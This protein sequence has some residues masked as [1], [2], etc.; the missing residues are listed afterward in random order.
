[1]EKNKGK[2]QKKEEPRMFVGGLFP[3]TTS[4]TV[5][6]YFQTFGEVKDVKIIGEKQK[7]SRGFGF[8]LFGSFDTLNR[9]MAEKHLIDGREVDCNFAVYSN[10]TDKDEAA[11]KNEKKIFLSSL[12][13]AVVK[14]DLVDTFESFGAIEKVMIV[15]RKNKDHSFGFVIFEDKMSAKKALHIKKH[16]IRGIECECQIAQPKIRSYLNKV[17]GGDQLDNSK[18]LQDTFKVKKNKK[19]KKR[20]KKSKENSKAPSKI[21]SKEADDLYHEQSVNNII[22]D[23]QNNLQRNKHLPLDRINDQLLLNPPPRRHNT[24]DMLD[25]KRADQSPNPNFDPQPVPTHL[26]NSK[27]PSYYPESNQMKGQLN[28]I[29]GTQGMGNI[30]NMP[31]QPIHNLHPGLNATGSNIGQF[32]NYNYINN[33]Y[34]FTIPQVPQE[35]GQPIQTHV[36]MQNVKIAQ[37]QRSEAQSGSSIQYLKNLKNK[38]KQ[39]L[40]KH[41]NQMYESHQSRNVLHSPSQNHDLDQSPVGARSKHSNS[42]QISITKII[43][44]EAKIRCKK[45]KLKIQNKNYRFNQNMNGS[46]LSRDSLPSQH[47]FG[48][49]ESA[50]FP[51]VSASMLH[52]N[53]GQTQ[54][55]NQTNQNDKMW[56]SH[57]TQITEQTNKVNN[58]T[59]V[60]SQE[61]LGE[62]GL[63]MPVTKDKSLVVNKQPIRRTV[64]QSEKEK[65]NYKPGDTPFKDRTS[66]RLGEVHRKL[67][68]HS[69][70]YSDRVSLNREWSDQSD[71]EE[72]D[73]PNDIEVIN[74]VIVRKRANSA[75]LENDEEQ[76]KQSSKKMATSAVQMK[77]M[78]SSKL[79]FGGKS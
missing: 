4:Q 65:K 15:K 57:F 39:K 11:Q 5:R 75:D 13:S 31:Q 54:N 24:D 74:E 28:A 40:H 18:E 7:R 69:Q 48:S 71:N 73:E 60:T 32:N 76:D 1:M 41:Q 53:Y 42:S 61:R 16:T 77:N 68:K 35:K 12:P 38:N 36:Q 9:V 55:N 79:T 70:I 19:K 43:N 52:P 29:L 17:K 58:N 50:N 49:N 23:T 64:T 59:V 8:V 67:P 62:S 37:S 6:Q 63:Y 3:E 56:T 10:K 30:Q 14:Q 20:G 21:S 72:R 33:H 47:T 34:H 46:Q 45:E 26:I 51:Q 27:S 44:E 22:R 78:K 66:G 2:N 25:M